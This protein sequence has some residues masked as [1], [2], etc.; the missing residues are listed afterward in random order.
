MGGTI[1]AESRTVEQPWLFQWE[2]DDEV[3]EFWDQPTRMQISYQNANGKNQCFDVTF[4]F[5]V[6]RKNKIQLIECKSEEDLKALAVKDS[7]RWK[8]DAQGNWTSPPAEAQAKLRGFEFLIL[9]PGQIS[10]VLYQNLI[11]LS[12]YTLAG[13]YEE[14]NVENQPVLSRI[15]ATLGITMAALLCG[16]GE[17]RVDTV[18]AMIAHGQIHVDLSC[19]SLREPDL[20]HLY[21]HRAHMLAVKH[22]G[23]QK[24]DHE[25]AT[26]SL[27]N[28]FRYSLGNPQV[29]GASIRR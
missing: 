5:L 21:Y 1:Q 24:S 8:R 23:C 20:V 7:G 11:Y 17:V 19:A 6:I 3:L 18:L 22:F 14:H 29:D 2:H 25:A 27:T 28:R 10:P 26:P 13:S 12:D 9:T 15:K 16:N 4:D